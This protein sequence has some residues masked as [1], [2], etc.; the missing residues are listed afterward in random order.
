MPE[1]IGNDGCQWRCFDART[2][3]RTDRSCFKTHEALCTFEAQDEMKQDV[4]I[5]IIDRVFKFMT[6]LSLNRCVE[7][8]RS[9]FLSFVS[10]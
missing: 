5:C 1:A 10:F 6:N 7:N 3:F 4:A 8:I 2:S 9:S